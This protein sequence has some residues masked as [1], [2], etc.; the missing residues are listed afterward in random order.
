MAFRAGSNQQE[1]FGAFLASPPKNETLVEV[2]KLIDW[3]VLRAIMAPVYKDASRGGRPGF[4][5]VL[6]FKL[7]LL[8]QWYN[9][10]PLKNPSNA[11]AMKGRRVFEASG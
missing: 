11:T 9:L 7:L 5:P 8:E 1:V 4:D 6:M 10:G 3:K 2:E